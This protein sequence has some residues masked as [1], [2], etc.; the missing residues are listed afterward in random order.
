MGPKFAGHSSAMRGPFGTGAVEDGAR[1]K[2]RC[3]AR[4]FGVWGQREIEALLRCPAV[5][6]LGSS[7]WEIRQRYRSR[8]SRK[9]HQSC[10]TGLWSSSLVPGTYVWHCGR[11]LLIDMKIYLRHRL[12]WRVFTY[13]LYMKIVLGFLSKV[14]TYD[15]GAKPAALRWSQKAPFF[16]T[17]KNVI[18]WT[19]KKSVFSHSPTEVVDHPKKKTF[20]RTVLGKSW[21]TQKAQ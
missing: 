3:P 21:T 12:L 10:R 20:F 1:R 4:Q 9:S 11:L 6:V 2:G 5:S 19:R 14:F 16:L 13:D 7:S 18:F 17:R 15:Q 8:P